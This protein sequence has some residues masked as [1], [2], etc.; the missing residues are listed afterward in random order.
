MFPA[1]NQTLVKLDLTLRKREIL[2]AA[3]IAD[4]SESIGHSDQT[5]RSTAQL[6]APSIPDREFI[7]AAQINLVLISHLQIPF[8]LTRAEDVR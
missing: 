8:R 4:R 7:D 5:Y 3:D 1:L 6:E 2:V